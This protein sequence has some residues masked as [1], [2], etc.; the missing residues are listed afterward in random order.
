MCGITGLW[1]FS[2]NLDVGH[3][4]QN[5]N[6]SLRHRGP[7][8]QGLWT[9]NNIALGHRRLSIVDL[10]NAGHQPMLSTDGRYILVFNGEIYNYKQIANEL[11]N[12][13][14]SYYFNNDTSVLLNA[15]TYWGIDKTLKKLN[16]MFA[17][18][19]YDALDKKLIVARDHFGEKPLYYA[20][21]AQQYFCF[22][23]ELKA[24]KQC[25]KI[26]LTI[27]PTA[28]NLYLQFN[29][30]PC[31]YS[32][33]ENVKKLFPGHYLIVTEKGFRDFTYYDLG[34]NIQ[35]RTVNQYSEEEYTGQLKDKISH[36]VRERMEADVPLGAFLSGGIDSSLM[37]AL[38]QSIS[39]KPIK[40]FTVGFKDSPW[41]ESSYA[42]KI[43]DYLHTDHQTLFI[44]QEEVLKDIS[45]ITNLYDEPFGDA[46]ALSTY[47]ICKQISKYVTV[48][49]SGDGGDELFGGYHRQK[50]IPRLNTYRKFL[51][52]SLLNIAQ[53]CLPEEHLPIFTGKA[54]KA[55]NALKGKNF[56]ETY[57]RSVQYWDSNP[58]L[59]GTN[60][61]IHSDLK[62]K[63]EQVMFLDMK[64]F[65]Q[66]DVLCKVDRASMAT[67][68]ETRAP[69]LD[70][71]LVDFAWSIPVH[72]KIHKGCK[73]YLLKKLLAQY[74]PDELWDRPKMGF[75]MPLANVFRTSL[76]TT[77]E[78]YLSSDTILWQ[79]LDQKTVCKLFSQHLSGKINHENLLWN[80]FVAQHFLLND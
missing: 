2:N 41:D 12:E 63:T 13:G 53:K 24:L 79:F 7:N 19:V 15:C 49:M 30:I 23:S 57:I 35:K 48:A 61:S 58:S 68:L 46:S 3:I 29:Y 36:A 25:P 10:T 11:L 65:M 21:K 5:M 9:Q 56:L 64:T 28:L 45:S 38:M 62:A 26:D 66:D 51:P 31:P 18:G 78:H 37:V 52:T 77:F 22:G 17:F 75:G 73:K 47:T 72:L 16:G 76:K 20:Y 59:L 27:D 55:L 40:T 44:D 32:I 42:K 4:V 1:D 54:K 6:D 39:S 50:W 69:F 8:D 14:I 70:Y 33:Y 80:F 34:S 71:D 67:S 43:A 60:F 74:L